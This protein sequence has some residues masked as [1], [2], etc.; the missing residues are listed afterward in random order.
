MLATV[1]EGFRIE[2]DDDRELVPISVITTMPSIDPWFRLTP[3][4]K[5]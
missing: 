4:E 3:M 2:L 5:G 1:L